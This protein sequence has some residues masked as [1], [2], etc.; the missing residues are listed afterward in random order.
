[1]RSTLAVLAIILPAWCQPPAGDPKPA[2]P[3][4]AAAPKRVETPDSKAANE[5]LNTD[6]PAAE[7]LELMLKFFRDFPSSSRANMVRAQLPAVAIE[8]HKTDKPALGA[9]LDAHAKPLKPLDASAF[10]LAA[11]EALQ[12]A[13]VHPDLGR[14][15]GRL[16]LKLYDRK[17]VA[18]DMADTAKRANRPAP[19]DKAVHARWNTTRARAF[20]ALGQIEIKDGHPAKGETLLKKALAANP[21]SSTAALAMARLAAQ[22]G[23]KDDALRYSSQALLTRPGADSRKAFAEAYAAARGGQAGAEDYLDQQYR[24]LFP[25]PVHAAR[26]QPAA[27]RS[28]RVVLAEVHTGSGCPPCAAADLAFDAAME[29]YSRAELAV[30]MY[31]Q[32]IPRPDPMTN[33]D[34]QARWKFIAGQGVPTYVIDGKK[35]GGGGPRDATGEVLKK[36]ETMIEAGLTKPAGAALQ[37]TATHTGSQVS[38]RAAIDQIQGEHKQLQLRVVLAEKEVRYSGEN[39]IRFHPMV[40]RGEASYPITGKGETA[41]IFDVAQAQ[42]KAKEHIDA[43]EK[44]DDRHNKDGKFRFAEYRWEINPAHLAVVAFLEDADTKEVLQSAYVDLSAGR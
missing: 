34:T 27:N 9:F 37:L 36:I 2:E 39:G 22:A 18:A 43:F 12:K 14:H 19:D 5:A 6:R 23:R 42:A 1:M 24:K 30:L 44:H 8:V 35:D 13:A 21:S 10:Y 33:F 38:A 29:R 16:A 26:Y 41:H 17:L 28:T 32:H 31:H 7:R 15:Y 40:V 3:P 20:E 4:K 25:L 11:A